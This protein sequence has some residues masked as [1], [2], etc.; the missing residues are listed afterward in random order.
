M[1][2]SPMAQENRR[3]RL[4]FEHTAPTMISITEADGVKKAYWYTRYTVINDTERNIP[5]M[6]QIRLVIDKVKEGVPESKVPE[7]F[8]QATIPE[9]YDKAE[10]LGNLQTYY[11]TDLP[12]VKQEILRQLQIYPRL[13]PQEKTVLDLLDNKKAKSAF[14]VMKKAGLSYYET[15]NILDRLVIQNLALPEAILGSTT[16]MEGKTDHAIFLIYG[17]PTQIKIGETVNGWQLF[18]FTSNRAIMKKQNV[19]YTLSQGMLLESTYIK[20]DKLPFERDDHLVSRDEALG[21]YKGRVAKDGAKQHEFRP[22]VIPKHS[23][24][25]GIAIFCDVSTEADFM[26]IVVSGLVD[27]IIRRNRKVWVEN[28]VLLCGYSRFSSDFQHHQTKL[29]YQKSEVLSI[30]ELKTSPK[31]PPEM[32]EE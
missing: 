4:K 3:W 24:I 31:K 12:A 16:F 19:L 15:R 10:Y 1:L 26:G 23:R 27:P 20:S 5:W 30:K 28:E 2:L 9:G 25:E 13:T 22:A 7:V 6:V 32:R 11:D 14:E 18:S 21:V 8:Y 29:L 17:L